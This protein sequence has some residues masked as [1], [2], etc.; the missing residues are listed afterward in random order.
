MDAIDGSAP[1]T[2]HAQKVLRAEV[3]PCRPSRK[4]ARRTG[5]A[6]PLGEMFDHGCDAMNTTVSDQRLDME[7]D[8]R[9]DSAD[10]LLSSLQLEVLICAHALNL[11]RSWWTV[12]SQVAALSNFYL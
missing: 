7:V 1:S 2:R 6:G 5:M 12:A 4:Q 8:R 10:R 11:G 3:P 9:I